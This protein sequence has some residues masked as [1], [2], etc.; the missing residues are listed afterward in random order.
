M[1]DELNRVYEA[2]QK[3][4]Q[5]GNVEDAKQLASYARQLE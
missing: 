2:L 5:A 4:D 1:S 3:A